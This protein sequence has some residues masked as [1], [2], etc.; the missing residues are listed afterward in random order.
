MTTPFKPLSALLPEGLLH[1]IC[2]NVPEDEMR[3]FVLGH[4]IRHFRH[5]DHLQGMG[6]A[7]GFQILM[8]VVF[9]SVSGADIFGQSFD[10]IF[11][12]RY[13]QERE[14]MADRYGLEL[15]HAAYGKV[16]GADRLFRLLQ[17]NDKLPKWAYMFSTHPAAQKRIEDLQA[18]AATLS[19][20]GVSQ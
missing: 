8:A 15:V 12:R 1:D 13:S 7:I 18:H 9:G 4:K 14:K 5:R 20:S 17:D 16:E 11:A 19:K 10:F 3:R 2:E 6:R